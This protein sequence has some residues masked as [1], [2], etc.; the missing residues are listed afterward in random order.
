MTNELNDTPEMPQEP[1]EFQK[2]E[3]TKARKSC[4]SRCGW[5]IFAV[6]AA[7][8]PISLVLGFVVGAFGLMDFYDKNLLIF[9][10]I[11][12][13]L[14]M[15]CGVAVLF[16]M[17][18]SAPE[19]KG[20]S[21]KE[22]IALLCVCATISTVGSTIS[23]YFIEF[24]NALTGSSASDPVTDLLMSIDPWQVLLCTGIIAPIIE[25]FLF[26]KMLI[27]RMRPLGVWPAI[28]VSAFLFALFHQNIG[29]LFYTF[30][31]GVI[32]AY[33]YCRTG[34]FLMVTLLHMAFNCIFGVIPAVLSLKVMPFIEAIAGFATTDE[35]ISAIPELLPQYGAPLLLF[36]V[37]LLV[38]GA[39]NI[40]G[41]VIIIVNIKKFAIPKT[42]SVLPS[43]ERWKAMLLN[44]GMIAAIVINAA[45]MLLSLIAS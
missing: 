37:Y 24:W 45:L 44:G 26:R 13:A 8:I 30:G 11:F 42:E 33:L 27:D 5:A 17:P 9:N 1:T 29:Q 2:Y 23:N 34:K 28:I 3:E 16:S 35:L 10:E 32:L 19:Q 18:K 7:T 31:F 40:A 22:F 20:V 4:F 12:I 14:A 6:A 41:I 21:A 39:M 43:K 38:R 15:L 36:G 25:E